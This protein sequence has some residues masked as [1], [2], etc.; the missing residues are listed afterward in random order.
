MDELESK[1]VILY[2]GVCGLCNRLNQFVLPRD[3]HDQFRFA[4][5]QSRYAQQVLERHG[6]DA[7]DLDTLYVV[8][9]PAQPDEYLLWKS[10]A[11]LFILMRLGGLWKLSALARIFPRRLRDWVYDRV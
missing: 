11:A 9:D 6:R 7:R 2:D 5:L 10:A 1:A 4:A 3:A 8:V